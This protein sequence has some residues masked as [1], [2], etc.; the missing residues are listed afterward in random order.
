MGDKDH[1]PHSP[2]V[3]SP[4]IKVRVAGTPAV[5]SRPAARRRRRRARRSISPISRTAPS[6]RPR[7]RSISA[8]ATWAWRPAGSDRENSGHHHL[9][10]DTELP[11]LDQPI[12]SDFNHLHFGGGQTEAEITL[13]HGEHTLQ[14]LHGRQGSYPAHAA[15]HV[16]PHQGAGGRSV[17]AQAVA[18]GC[19][20]LFRRP[21]GLVGAAAEGHHPVWARPTWA[22]HRPASK[23][24]TPAITIC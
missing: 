16:A 21:A 8:C 17:A 9:L 10:I 3:M 15:G 23:R 5:G 22:W 24:R 14:L 11:P 12:P 2:P 4:R 1:V 7:P 20:G 6:S 13:K 18:A 19:A